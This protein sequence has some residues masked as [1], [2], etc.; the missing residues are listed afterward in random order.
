MRRPAICA[1]ALLVPVALAT[2]CS[3]PGEEATSAPTT[4]APAATPGTTPAISATGSFTA[5]PSP[6]ASTAT[7]AT[8]YS[9]DPTLA[10]AGSAA[11]V[12]ATSGEATTTVKLVAT[13]FVPGRAYGAHLH[14]NPCGADS[15]ASGPHFQHHADPAASQSP[16]VDPKYANPQNEVWL[17]FTTDADGNATV[18][19]ELPWTLADDRR[20]RALVVHAEK[21]RT[22]AGKAGTAGA[23]VACLTLGG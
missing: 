18:T 22:E 19:A 7:P 5:A 14:V 23:R 8:A 20:P 2:G 4:T 17:D 6:A 3:S 21:T 12:T 11:Q 15:K 9:Y 1:L 10:P 13:G 16:S